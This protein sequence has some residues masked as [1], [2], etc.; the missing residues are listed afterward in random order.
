M[1]E[2]F[3]LVVSLPGGTRA[4]QVFLDITIANYESVLVRQK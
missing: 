3:R 4:L 2:E 1:S